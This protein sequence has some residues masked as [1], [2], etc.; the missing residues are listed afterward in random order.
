MLDAVWSSSSLEDRE[1]VRRSKDG[2]H[3]AFEALAAKYQRLLL[4][5]IRRYAAS[6]V[7]KDD[8]L[9]LLMCKIYFS[10]NAFDVNRPFYPWLRRVAINMCCDARRRWRRKALIFADL[11]PEGIEAR[12]VSLSIDSYAADRGQEMGEMLQIAIGMLPKRHREVITLHHLQQ[13]PY[14]E[15]GAMLKCTA[16]AA[17]ARAFRARVALRQLLDNASAEEGCVASS[18]AVDRL[19]ACCRNNLIKSSRYV[20]PNDDI[21]MLGV[22]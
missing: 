11:E 3:A 17:R 20:R 22:C 6:I 5:L 12:Q 2:D 8:L 18:S 15:I 19:D 7:D 10:L 16:R 1:L 9:Q 13:R 4:M 14:E 21:K